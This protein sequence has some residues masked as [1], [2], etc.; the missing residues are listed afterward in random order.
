MKLLNNGGGGAIPLIQYGKK[1]DNSKILR[2]PQWIK[3]QVAKCT[4]KANEFS[5]QP[6]KTLKVCPMCNS[7]A[8]QSYIEIYGFHYAECKNCNNLF[9]TN[10]LRN[11]AQLYEN[12]GTESS[13]DSAYYD[14][15]VFP[16]RT[17]VISKPK[18][19]FINK[20]FKA[21]HKT[22]N[23]LWLD[24]GCGAGELLYVAKNLGFKT[25]GFESDTKA[26]QFANQKLKGNVVQEGFLDILN[27][28][29]NL[30]QSI[31]KAKIISFLN[32]LEHL[33]SPKETL[34][35]FGKKM[36]KDSLL[37]IEVPRHPSLASFANLVA[38]N[39][40]YRHL[41][42]PFH[43]NIFSEKSLELVYQKAGFKLVGKWVYGQ[44]FMDI[45]HAFTQF[46]AQ[47]NLYEQMSKISNEVQKIID[48]NN[49]GDFLLLVLQ[50]I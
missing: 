24:I 50:K 19:H 31:Q 12:D 4:S 42:P 15:N 33:E 22:D 9:L 30:L 1:F 20:V 17:K 2:T 29:L 26:V 7:G 39:L 8:F 3:E 38:P 5:K 37:V 47:K 40:V 16:I 46:D 41:I 27:C 36:K 48:K 45:I 6:R 13:F 28:D 34:E 49:L 25:L 18:A 35:F 11:I 44:G 43:L 14:N 10:P 32:T 21:L 23:P